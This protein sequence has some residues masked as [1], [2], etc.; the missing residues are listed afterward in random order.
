M[1]IS[2]AVDL[3]KV[4]RAAN[5]SIP[6]FTVL[7][8]VAGHVLSF[9]FHFL[10]VPLL[11]LSGLNAYYLFGQ[12]SHALL[13]NFG[14]LAQM[15]YF[16]ESVGPEFRQYLFMSDTEEMP[17]NRVERA[18]V[19][20]KAKG[21]D[22]ASAF[23]SQAS[24]SGT[25][26]KLLHSL[27]P[28]PKDEIEAYRVT[29]GEERAVPS[30]YTLQKPLMISAMSYGSLGQRAVR[31][32]ARGAKKAGIP[33]NTGEG[34]Y[35]KYHLMEECD[36]IFQMGTAKFGVRHEDGTLDEQ[37]LADLA[38]QPSVR[39]IEIKLSQGAKPG[40]GGLLPK[41]KI[42]EEIA[43]LRGVPIGKD[44]VS[45]PFHAECRDVASTVAFI[46]RVQEV[47]GLPVGIKLCLG[48][49]TELVSLFVEMR[50][51][52]SFPDWISVDG[53][54]GGTGAAPKAFM[55]DFGV[56]LLEALPVVDA[57]LR[58]EGIRKEMKIFAAGKL[59]NPGKQLLALSLGADAVYTARGFML[60]IGCIQALQCN[61]NTCPVGITTHRPELERG[62][63]IEKKSD[64][65]ANYVHALQHD[66]EEAMSALGR[67]TFGELSPTNV[68]MPGRQQGDSLLT[69]EEEMQRLI[70]LRSGR[71]PRPTD[72]GAN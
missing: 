13:A 30:A 11:M 22:S 31:A 72:V 42:T 67:R 38:A 70:Q 71:P 33:M 16:L 5:V 4:S 63:D 27:F 34:G 36:L 8:F 26:F 19:Y 7:S 48:R 45:P 69:R 66:W 39:M 9:Y 44:V 47:S 20:R 60:A 25:E 62:L 17:F 35:P 37:R 23:G 68:L 55:D 49:D 14:I 43:A 57:R 58:E 54:E 2:F 65:V 15:R 6:V 61:A 59:I 29:I 40:K 3:E 52:R 12:K 28:V 64:R 32:L 41:E 53:A 21:M 24:F 46:R 56:P 50:N 10:T 51:Q 18:E 1:A